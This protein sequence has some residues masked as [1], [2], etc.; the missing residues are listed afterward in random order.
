MHVVF[1]A[2]GV[3]SDGAMELWRAGLECIVVEAI[4]QKRIGGLDELGW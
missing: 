2:G 1:D 3:A 4:L